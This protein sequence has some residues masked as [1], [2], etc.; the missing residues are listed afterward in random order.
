[1]GRAKEQMVAQYRASRRV[2]A[3]PTSTA[4]L[5]A[6]PAALSMWPGLRLERVSDGL[7]HA[8]VPD[9]EDQHPV[10]VQVLPPHRTP[11][12]FVTRFEARGEPFGALA[13]E[14]TLAYA[15]DGTRAELMLETDA[16]ELCAAADAF[17][18]NLAV[19]ARE[20]SSAA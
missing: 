12:S 19:A 2:D 5:L 9:G 14:L 17:L 15:G 1:M 6:S 3:D 10:S 4:L 20:R 16:Q 13:G 18:D 7:V 11:T 8:T